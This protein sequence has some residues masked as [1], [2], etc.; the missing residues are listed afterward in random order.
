MGPMPK[1]KSLTL[2]RVLVLLLAYIMLAVCGGVA[3][4]V[5]FVPGVIGANKAAKAV[6][7][8]LKVENV[9]FDVTSLPQKS[10][11]YARDGSTVIATFYNQNRIVVPLKKISKTMQQAVVAREDRRFWTHAGVDVQGVMRAFVQTY[12]VKGSQQGG[13]SLT[14]QYVK[15]V[16][17]MQA[18]EDDDS[19][20]Q[21]HATEDTIARKIREML[22]S[23]QMEKKYSKAEI[24]QGY[25]NIAQFGN[26]LYGVE[27]AA[28]RYFSVSAADLNVVQSATIAAI[29]KNP[30]AYDPS[31]ESNQP[32]SEKQR[33]IVLQLMNEQGY[34]SDAEYQEAVNTPLADTLDVQP[35]STGCMAADYDAGY[36]CD[37]VVH[38]ILN[39]KEFG[40][41]SEDRERLLKEGGLKIVTTLDIDANT[42]LNETARNTIPPEDS[43][44]MEIV[45]ASV[46]PGTGEVLGF[47]L[48][49][50]YDATEAAQNDQGFHELC[51]GSRRRRRHGL[52]HRLVVEACQSGGM[53]GS[54]TFRQRKPADVHEV[55]DLVVRMRSLY[56]RH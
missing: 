40:K 18:I 3:A 41:T 35:I 50:T 4:S 24:L 44:G 10:T 25:L 11:M 27:T 13:S 7:P 21:Y 6:I 23:V 53:D 22:I 49:R 30:N 1:K 2:Q 48:N 39:S 47:G 36:F 46:K 26:N 29:T 28:Q 32:E 38:K 52:L 51:R 56:R 37:Y 45:M 31:V 14:Q 43:S 20:A 12:L 34:I 55:F 9:D 33:N 5:L 42:L 16:L 19:I 17:L 54:G 15:N 8:S